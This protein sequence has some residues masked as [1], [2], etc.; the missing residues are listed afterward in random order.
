MYSTSWQLMA[1]SYCNY[2][3]CGHWQVLSVCLTKRQTYDMMGC[4]LIHFVIHQLSRNHCITIF[5][6]LGVMCCISYAELSTW[7]DN[8]CFPTTFRSPL[9]ECIPHMTVTLNWRYVFISTDL[10]STHC[11][12]EIYLKW[13]LVHST[14][15]F[16]KNNARLS[17]N[18]YT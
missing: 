10:K 15:I 2:S 17:C 13:I 16:F 5:L 7:S 1:F 8:N 14:Y 18:W 9:W 3:T 11:D 6:L 12:D 4:Y